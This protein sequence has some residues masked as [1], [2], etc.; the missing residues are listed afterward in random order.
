V[1]E[2]LKAHGPQT[3]A[4]L[5]DLACARFAA[6]P[7]HRKRGLSF[8]ICWSDAGALVTSAAKPV[9]NGTALQLSPKLESETAGRKI[10]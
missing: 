4:R 6:D 9:T 2:L 8:G 7:F 1:K 10:I 3:A 5:I